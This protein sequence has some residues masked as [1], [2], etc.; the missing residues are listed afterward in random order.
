M[1]ETIA[2]MQRRNMIGVVSSQSPQRVRRWAEAAPDRF[3]PALMFDPV[4]NGDITP[5]SLRRL[6]KTGT[7]KVLGE[8]ETQ[9]VGIEPSDARMAPYWA[10]AE[11]LDV[12]VA[13]HMGEGYPG[14]P[15]LGDSSYRARLG[16]PFLLE[17][18]LVRY[19]KL[20]AYVM[21][22]GSP[23]V[24][25]MISVLYTHPQLYVDIGGNQLL[26]YPREYFYG[27]LRRLMDAGF[28][29]RIMFGSDQMIWPGVIEPGIAVIE[30]APFLTPGQKR[31]ILYNNAARFLRLSNAEIE[32]HHG[33][34][35]R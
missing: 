24:D 2:V 6:V 12:P 30:E 26:T 22:Y 21:H 27:H 31:D 35:I 18:V 3:I 25:E 20:R 14:A 9:Y 28:G 34:G 4:E 7:V 15:Y 8:I 1:T 19:P 5:D 16:S 29:K 17:E 11:E 13:I 32:K 23:L 10:L 33:K